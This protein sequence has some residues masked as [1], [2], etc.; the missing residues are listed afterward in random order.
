MNN[1]LYFRAFVRP[2]GEVFDMGHTHCR[3]CFPGFPVK[4]SS[5]SIPAWPARPFPTA[6]CVGTTHKTFPNRWSC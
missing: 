4:N 1:E 2:S 3:S 6:R 5:L